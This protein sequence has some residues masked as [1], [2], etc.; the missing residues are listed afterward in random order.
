MDLKGSLR[1]LFGQAIAMRRQFLRMSPISSARQNASSQERS[2]G[3]F[4]WWRWLYPIV[5][6][7]ALVWCL[8]RVI[9]KPTRATYPCQRV[10][11]PLASS[12]V[13]WLSGALASAAAYRKAK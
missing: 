9:P 3:S 1:N 10:A 13:V 11:F 8:I 12:F 4:G 2:L 6:L 5:G 7:S